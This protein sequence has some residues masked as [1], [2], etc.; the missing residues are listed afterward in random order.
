MEWAERR[1]LTAAQHSRQVL[2]FH[3][4]YQLHTQMATTTL[5]LQQ[6]GHYLMVVKVNQPLLFQAV[7]D[8]F[9]QPAWPEEQ[10][11]V[12]QT[13]NVGHSR[14]DHRQLERRSV[15]HLPVLWPGMQQVMQ[16]VTQSWNLTTGAVRQEVAYAITSL[17]VPQASAA[18]LQAYWRG[19]WTIENRVHY[20]CDV[21]LLEGACRV[22][23]GPRATRLG[24]V[25]QRPHDAIAVARRHQHRPRLTPSRRSRQARSSLG[26]DRSLKMPCLP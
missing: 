20:M 22:R 7:T 14:R 24:G 2:T 15:V 17:P 1:W 10:A 9:A 4:I 19:H 5:M 11:S 13:C 6:G 21:T 23:A 25:T 18:D 12:V 3:V 8:W 26:R 16:R